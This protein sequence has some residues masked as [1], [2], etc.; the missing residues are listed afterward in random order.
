MFVVYVSKDGTNFAQLQTLATNARS[1]DLSQYALPAGNYKIFVKARGKPSIFNHLTS[2]VSFPVYSTLKVT[3]PTSN[4]VVS[5]PVSFNASASSPV[6]I[7]SIAL[8]VDGK[9]V[10]TVYSTTLSKSLTLS[11]GPHSY[12]YVVWDSMGRSTKEGGSITVH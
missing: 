8:K 5:S 7:K 9:T 10:Y 3:S 12:M 11:S 1:L 6:G 4:Q 2:G